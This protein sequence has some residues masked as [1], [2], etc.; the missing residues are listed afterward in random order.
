MKAAA[1]FEIPKVIHVVDMPKPE[2]TD[3]EFLVRMRACSLCYTDVKA[4][5]RGKHFFIELYGLPWVPGHEMSGE[6]AAVGARVEGL[7]V[8]Q[9]VAVSPYVP[10]G[11]C[12]ACRAG[13][14]RFCVQAPFSFVQ[15]GGFAEYFKVPGNN[16]SLRALPIP[17]GVSFE[18]AA[19]TEPVASCLHAIRKTNIGLGQT[20]T[21]I[22]AGPMGLILLQLARSCGAG[23]VIML[24]QQADRLET[25]RTLGADTLI[26]TGREDPVARVKEVTGYLGSDV[27]IEAVGTVATYLL[28]LQLA[29][30]G[31]TVNFFG[32]L[33]SGTVV[34]MSSDMLHYQ[35]LTLVGTSSFSPDDY[36]NALKMIA[37]GRIDV[38]RLISHR[39][40]ALEGVMAAIDLTLDK[41]GLKKVVILD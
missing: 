24:D 25:A 10:C 1:L 22:G 8:G 11:R 29:R 33:P 37:A 4:S 28:A 2:I 17:D 12:P 26:D 16:A 20:V 5:M 21:I 40:T 18:E 15:P 6:V 39:F 41:K 23:Q 38:K 31:G 14:Y 35:E 9:A 32:G 7:K 30:G 27:V 3:D 19:L 36:E 34:E 13:S